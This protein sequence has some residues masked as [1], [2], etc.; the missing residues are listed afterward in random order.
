MNHVLHVQID[1][2]VK[3]IKSVCQCLYLLQYIR[4]KYVLGAGNIWCTGYFYLKKRK[5]KIHT[6]AHLINLFLC[7]FFYNSLNYGSSK[8]LWQTEHPNTYLSGKTFECFDD[9]ENRRDIIKDRNSLFCLFCWEVSV[10]SWWNYWWSR[11][12]LCCIFT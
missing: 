8:L 5:L 3:E 12:V 9:V 1:N 7:K 10:S 6:C 4:K 2:W 11:V